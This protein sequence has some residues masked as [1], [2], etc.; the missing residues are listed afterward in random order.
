MNASF[1]T[2]IA[3]PA[4]GRLDDVRRLLKIIAADYGPRED[5]ELLV[6]D[7]SP[8]GSARGAFEE[9]GESFGGRARYIH[10]PHRGYSNVRNALLANVGEVDAI[11]MIDD[12]EIPASGWLDNLLAA[13]ANSGADIVAGPVIP[14]FPADVPAWYAASGVFDL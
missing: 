9:Y 11:A 12:D 14:E 7:N 4:G 10:E 8:D 3:V 5:V 13:Q 2:L 6:A 1:V